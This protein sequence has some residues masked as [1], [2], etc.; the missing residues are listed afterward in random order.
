LRALKKAEKKRRWKQ[1]QKEKAAASASASTST[2]DTATEALAAQTS[3]QA[4]TTNKAVD[5]AKKSKSSKS[6]KKSQRK[7][8]RRKKETVTTAATTTSTADAETEAPTTNDDAISVNIETA[9]RPLNWGPSPF[10]NLEA[11]TSTDEVISYD[12][13]M[14]SE[15]FDVL[16]PA[17]DEQPASSKPKRQEHRAAARLLKMSG[18][19]VR[20]PARSTNLKPINFVPAKSTTI[21]TVPA[22]PEKNA[23]AKA[24]VKDTPAAS[25]TKVKAITST[26]TAKVSSEITKTV[27]SSGAKGKTKASRTFYEPHLP[28]EKALADIKAGKL[29]RG[30]FRI[31]KRNRNDG[32]VTI[33]GQEGADIMIYGN[34]LQNRAFDGDIVAVQLLS[35]EEVKRERKER[36]KAIA[37]RRERLRGPN[38]SD[39]DEAEKKPT[40]PVGWGKIVA[41]LEAGRDRTFVG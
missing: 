41:I 35:G 3:E 13:L 18:I 27:R 17:K 11:T 32:Y 40:E 9:S 31:N 21:N 24:A 36:E 15:K 10:D 6:E 19:N 22:E 28:R 26:L 39:K 7:E 1:R 34:R 14:V 37:R 29:L 38:A 2:T 5:G 25:T 20:P 23:R 4:Q 12:A 30:Q 8:R 16:G 33:E